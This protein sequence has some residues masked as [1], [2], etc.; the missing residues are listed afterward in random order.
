MTS[1]SD[2]YE[3]AMI[4]DKMTPDQVYIP[5]PNLN[6]P[7]Q[8]MPQ[9]KKEFVSDFLN[10]L[11]ESGVEVWR[12]NAPVGSLRPIQADINRPKVIGMMA[13]TVLEK[14]M[15]PIVS[16]D[17]Y[18]LDGHHRWLALLNGAMQRNDKDYQMPIWRVDTDMRSLLALA[19]KFP[20]IQY[21][22]IEESLKWA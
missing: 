21:K 11:R 2:W 5:G 22:S 12:E 15:P 20:D 17:N 1:F 4:A 16:N 6:V 18:I 19:K 8:E 9:V 10:Y 3:T 14:G 7:R 13:N